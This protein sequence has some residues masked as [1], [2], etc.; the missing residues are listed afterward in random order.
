MISSWN[1]DKI[2][3]ETSNGIVT[4]PI[5]KKKIALLQTKLSVLI[6]KRKSG[7]MLTE[8]ATKTTRE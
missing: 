8:L 2:G 7:L 4:C 1:E 5:V 6:I 3:R